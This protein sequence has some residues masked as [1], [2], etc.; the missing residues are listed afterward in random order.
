MVSLFVMKDKLKIVFATNNTHK[1][2]EIREIM[3]DK[4][5][6]LSLADIGCHEDIPE[7][8]DTIEG[9]AK[10]KACYV[11]D[12]YGV[13]C[14][15]DDTGLEVEALGGA[16]GVHT[17]RYASAEGHD[18]LGNM[19]LL[20]NNLKGE[21]NRQASFVTVIAFVRKT[22]DGLKKVDVF[23]GICEGNIAEHPTGNGG[24]GYDPV[25]IPSGFSKSFAQ[26]S[27]EEK[28]SVSHRGRATRKFIK[29]ISE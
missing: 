25:F 26:M 15:A 16:P 10:E 5:D 28:N 6:I 4:Y 24:F 12:H 22:D 23:K 2:K 3:G 20:L 18:T 29:F 27:A 13:D 21:N 11:F 9:N 14:F 17:A 8:A 1:L 19:N 7:T